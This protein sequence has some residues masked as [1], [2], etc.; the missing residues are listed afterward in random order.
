[1]RV[2]VA[3]VIVLDG[4]LV[5][6]RHRGADGRTYHLL[7]GGGVETGESLSDAVEREVIEETGLTVHP[8][9]LLWVNDT[10]DPRGHRHA[11]N[12]TFLAE[13]T[14][15]SVTDSP[16]DARVEGV[17]LV[18]PAALS[19]MDLRPP[20][21]QYLAEGFA[22]GFADEARYLGPLWVDAPTGAGGSG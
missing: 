4:Q 20:I 7:P 2:R 14:A 19:S 17:D 11:V 1:M 9:R 16:L 8:L 6:A 21:A 18:E 13:V 10:I 15:G 12:L 22:N 5:L 3:A